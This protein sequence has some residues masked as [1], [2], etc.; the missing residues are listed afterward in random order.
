[1]CTA[2]KGGGIVVLCRS[3]VLDILLGTVMMIV[4]SSRYQQWY[5]LISNLS[6]EIA[7]TCRDRSQLVVFQPERYSLL[8]DKADC[9]L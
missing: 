4:F 9:V 8:A 2:E 7:K 6:F 1:M 3:L 5:I